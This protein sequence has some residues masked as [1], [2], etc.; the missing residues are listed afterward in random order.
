[1]DMALMSFVRAHPF[2]SWSVLVAG[3][4]A[5]VYLMLRPFTFKQF[6]DRIPFILCIP[7]FLMVVSLLILPK[8]FPRAFEALLGHSIYTVETRWLSADTW[9]TSRWIEKWEGFFTWPYFGSIAVGVLWAVVNLFRRRSC[10]IN[11]LAVLLGVIYLLYMWFV[12]TAAR[13]F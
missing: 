6:N 7:N 5:I 2:A 8:A 4:S 9:T 11:G 10:V 12:I 1:M 3:W 13:L